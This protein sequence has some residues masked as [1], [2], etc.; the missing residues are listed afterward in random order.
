VTCSSPKDTRTQSIYRLHDKALQLLATS[1]NITSIAAAG[2]TAYYIDN[3]NLARVDSGSNASETSDPATQYAMVRASPNGTLY[4]IIGS[5]GTYGNWAY[6]LYRVGGGSAA[7]V[8]GTSRTA[9]WLDFTVANDGRILYI[10]YYSGGI[11][12]IETDGSQ[13]LF[14]AKP[15]PISPQHLAVRPDGTVAY[16][17][18]S[19]LQV[20]PSAR[21]QHCLVIGATPHG[22]PRDSGFVLS[23]PSGGDGFQFT[24]VGRHE[25]TRN[26]ITG[27]VYTFTYDSNSLPIAIEDGNGLTTQITRTGTS[28]TITGPNGDVTGLQLDA[29]NHVT[30]ITTPAGEHDFT[31]T[32]DGLL[33]SHRDP[34][35]NISTYEYDDQGRLIHA[36][37]AAGGTKDLTPTTD[38]NFETTD[39]VTGLGRH[40]QY[41]TK[42]YGDGALDQ[43]VTDPLGLATTTSTTPSSTTQTFPDGTKIT[44]TR[45]PDPIWNLTG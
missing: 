31:Y 24:S 9:E 40:Y 21:L 15:A 14:D 45:A 23:A 8:P 2:K 39:L 44:T 42:D 18:F 34:R 6:S 41:I 16:T 12:V 4:A 43:T 5:Q 33:L 22:T 37:D 20:C 32:T 25:E 35:G 38:G 26:P 29:G 13:R 28:A 1:A 7:L 10:P 30:S 3:G 36:A 27:L 17:E 19:G 11:H